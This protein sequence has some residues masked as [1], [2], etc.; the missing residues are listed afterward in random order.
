MSYLLSILFVFFFAFPA[1]ADDLGSRLKDIEKTLKSQQ[2]LIDRLKAEKNGGGGGKLRLID[3]SM[4]ALIAVGGSTEDDESLQSL[5]G[6]GHDPRK[7]GFTVQ[8]IELSLSGAIDPYLMGEAHIIYFLDPLEGET[9]VELEEVFMTTISLPYGLQ[10]EAGHF[11]TEFGRINPRHPHQW[12]WQDQ[13]VINT[14]LFGPD[15][16]RGPGF[17]LGWL[18]PLPWFSE[19]HFGVQNA[20]GETMASFLASDEFFGERAIGGRPFVDRGVKT[21]KDLAYL[22]RLDNSLDLSDEVTASMGLSALYGPNATGAQGETLI[23]GA[24][25]VVKWRPEGG[26]RGWPFLVWETEVMKRDYKAASFYDDSDPSDIIDLSEETLKD[27]GLYTQLIYGFKPGWAAGLRYE[28]ATGSGESVGGRA[29][30]PFRDDR[31]RISPLVT[32]MPTEFSR[33][34]AQYNYD[35][36]DH[37]NDKEAHSVWLGVEFMY[38]AHAAHSF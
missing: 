31:R 9:V 13:P 37:L 25:L 38:G 19:L 8:N 34:R 7:R 35:R 26:V 24:D 27:W 15:G 32:W 12:H 5:Q 1:F 16:M 4:D 18:M 29:S 6:G 10:L 36:A 21:L 3:L 22:L 28:Y 17:R 14:R 2:E 11:F 30:D 20:N 33:F 23:Y